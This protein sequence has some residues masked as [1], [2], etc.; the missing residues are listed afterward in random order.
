MEALKA[1]QNVSLADQSLSFALKRME[2]IYD[3]TDGKPDEPHWHAYYT[4]VFVREGR[5]VHHID[6]HS[7]ELGENQVYFISPGQVHQIVEHE[8]SSGWALTFSPQFLLENGIDRNFIADLHLFQDFGFTPPLTLNPTE[9]A[10]LQFLAEEMDQLQQSHQKF[11]YEAVGAL[12][13]L[14]L[15]QCNHVCELCREE[16]TQ[17][18]QATVTLLREFKKLL[19]EKYAVWHK[20]SQYAEAMFITPDHLNA[21]VKALTHKSAKE[22]IQ[23]RIIVSAQRYLRHTD[24]PQKEIAYA[25][26]FSEP[27]NFSQFFKKCTGLSPTAFRNQTL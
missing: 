15:I 6:F 9:A 20:V 7:F 2:E 26:G 19:N 1:Y 10:R 27:A 12:L 18:V 17:T 5:G 14:F 8:K 11:R 4:I 25:L 23:S 16:N 13:K 22:H 24:L 3:K 21:S